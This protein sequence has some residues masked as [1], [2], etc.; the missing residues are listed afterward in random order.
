MKFTFTSLVVAAFAVTALPASAAAILPMAPMNAVLENTTADM[1]GF[2]A[3]DY[4]V[5]VGSRSSRS[6]SRSSTTR[7]TT[8]PA[9]KP[10]RQT[11]PSTAQTRRNTA[12]AAN[13]Q[14]NTAR[15]AATTLP[16]RNAGAKP[17]TDSQRQATAQQRR[18][19]IGGFQ[20]DRRA[21]ATTTRRNLTTSGS[22]RGATAPVRRT[23]TAANT[24]TTTSAANK[25]F[26][27]Q[28]RSTLASRTPSSTR[29]VNLRDRNS[30]GWNDYDSFY[31]PSVYYGH[32]P[33]MLGGFG[34][35]MYYGGGACMTYVGGLYSCNGGMSFLTGLQLYWMMD[36]IADRNR[37]QQHANTS[38]QTTNYAA[39]EPTAEE[40]AHVRNS[41][42]MAFDEEGEA[43]A[44]GNYTVN[45]Y[46]APLPTQLTVRF[47]VGGA[48][49]NY[50][51]A[52]GTIAQYFPSNVNPVIVNTAGAPEIM[53]SLLNASCDMAFTQ[54]DSQVLDTVGATTVLSGAIYP[55][56]AHLICSDA[57]G[58]DEVTDLRNSG[59]TVAIIR[60]SG[61]QVMWQNFGQ[62]DS[63][64]SDKDSRSSG[65]NVAAMPNKDAAANHVASGSSACTIM[66]SGKGSASV[67]AMARAVGGKVVDVYDWDL[68]DDG[69][70]EFGEIAN[71]EYPKDI[72]YTGTFSNTVDTMYTWASVVVRNDWFNSLTQDQQNAIA[73]AVEAAVPEIQNMVS[74]Q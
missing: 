45:S 42:G 62:M 58:I 49:N 11:S 17:T 41:G 2:Q 36:N 29:S 65:I 47:C 51:K 18:N 27:S 63:G 16:T 24:R 74:Y 37:L 72:L 19:Q 38:G 9:A 25:Q 34:S 66:V 68:N 43:P 57:S 30:R 26:V 56:Y 21:A 23:T 12:P 7:R 10:R 52:A 6:S 13:T 15:T 22:T 55:E 40:L 8:K 5:E 32:R 53:Q 67:E 59:E 50:D 73:D 71:G 31:S 70:Y 14:R 44:D 4:I 61:A 64:Y 46:A 39:N 3:G 28:R 33:T 48:G 1:S 60:N 54:E 69:Q 20:R 35:P